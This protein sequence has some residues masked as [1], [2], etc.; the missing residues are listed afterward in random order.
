MG[1]VTLSETAWGEH[2]EESDCEDRG[3]R[4]A[5]LVGFAKQCV[6]VCLRRVQ[7]AASTT[8]TGDRGFARVRVRPCLPMCRS[9]KET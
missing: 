2:L 9:T 5:S 1:R 4:S 6:A 8:R 7:A 3:V